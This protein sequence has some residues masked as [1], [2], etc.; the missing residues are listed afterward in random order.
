LDKEVIDMNAVKNITN[1]EELLK[2]FKKDLKTINDENISL[3]DN[4]FSSNN[5]DFQGNITG[6]FI[7]FFE[8]RVKNQPHH[9]IYWY[10]LGIVCQFA[11]QSE[12]ALTSF[13]NASRYKPL[14]FVYR[15]R[16]ITFLMQSNRLSEAI[17]F[18]CDSLPMG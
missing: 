16:L 6:R 3:L 9:S 17:D 13:K 18:C 10:G 11:G 14:N 12:Q 4:L 2:E 15:E 8:K 1:L 5:L 7:I